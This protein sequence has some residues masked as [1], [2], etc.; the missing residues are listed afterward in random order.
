MMY[1]LSFYLPLLFLVSSSYTALIG[2]NVIPIES[3]DV[4][5]LGGLQIEINS[6]ADNYYVLQMRHNDTDAFEQI[7]TS[8]VKGN[9]GRTLLTEPLRALPQ[10]H[11][12][13]L[14]Y[15]LAQPGDQDKDGIDDLTELDALPNSSPF[16]AASSVGIN[17]GQVAIDNRATFETLSVDNV[18]IPWAP[19]LDNREF[20]KFAVADIFSDNPQIYFINSNTHFIHADFYNS[21]GWYEMDFS[22]EI[23]Y[24]PNLISAN[25]TLGVYSFSYS[26]GDPEPFNTVQ[27]THEL[28]AKNMPFLTNNLSYYVTT[29]SEAEYF[30]DKTEFDNSRVHVVF[31]NEIFE[32]IEYLPLNLA[33]GFGLLRA[34]E[35]EDTPSATDIVLY[36]SVPNFL[37]RVGGIITSFIQTPLSHVNLRAIQDGVPNAFI[38]D[39]LSDPVISSLLGKHIY[40]KVEE[41]RYLIREATIQEVDAW[42]EDLR[43]SQGQVPKRNLDYKEIRPLADITFDMSDGFGAKCTNVAT[44]RTFGFPEGTIPDGYGVPFHYY[45]EFM[46]HNDFYTRA[47]E[48]L[49]DPEFETDLEY[50]IEALSDFRKDIRAAEMPQWILDDLEAMHRSFPEGTAVRCRSSTNNED[51]P[52]F[53][54]AG[55]Y[56][57]KTQHLDEGHISKSIKQVYASMWNFRA[58]EERDFYRIDHFQAAMGV[59]CHPNYQEEKANGVGVTIDPIYSTFFTNYI[60]TQVGENLVTNPDVNSIAEEIILEKIDFFEDRII[61]YSNQVADGELIMTEIY[62]DQIRD[63]MEKIHDEFALLYGAEGDNSFAMDIEYKITADDQLIIKQARP[64]VSFWAA[65]PPVSTIDD[66]LQV[67]LYPN[68]FVNE[69][70]ISYE[71]SYERI[72]ITDLM[73]RTQT[74]VVATDLSSIVV[75]AA[76]WNIGP[77]FVLGVQEDGSAQV[78]GKVIKK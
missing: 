56:T 30:N 19:F 33:E 68:P 75:D 66:Q 73:G 12:Q 17:D 18:I 53:S 50:R 15:A 76:Q 8:I 59:L 9:E 6:S 60:N 23:T 2:Q 46:L 71:G 4:D 48:I 55:L 51:L 67:A 32:D 41:D 78:L 31:E 27:K 26:L 24:Y 36:E 69:F 77:Y 39:P 65:L 40:Y 45:H 35:P 5:L 72:V 7:G 29:F 25:G 13:V 20:V 74:S 47:R 49:A 1:R 58:F 62:R 11:Y 52:G 21:V 61:R 3:Y 70:H 38:K 28:I 54:G 10:S 57:S 63:Y 42:F 16:N 44:M 34:L 14:E 64:W 37:P 22:G 43:P